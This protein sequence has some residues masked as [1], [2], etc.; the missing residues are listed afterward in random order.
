MKEGQKFQN[1]VANC[2]VDDK[3]NSVCLISQQVS[4]TPKGDEK[5]EL[6]S[7]YQ[8][9]YFT[10]GKEKKLKTI[11][12]VAGNIHIPA[13]VAFIITAK[14]A[15]NNKVVGQGKFITCSQGLCQAVAEISENDLS[16]ILKSPVTYVGILN[17][18][19]KQVSLPFSVKGLKEGLLGLK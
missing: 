6:V 1:W 5:P 10:Q 7:M 11:I 12:T 17:A 2:S 8:F 13:G 4:T 3:K 19:G 16:D 18:E 9:G 15:K 14:D